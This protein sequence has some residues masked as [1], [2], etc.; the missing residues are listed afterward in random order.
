MDRAEGGRNQATRESVSV[1]IPTLHSTVIDR[2][3]QSLFDQSCFDRITEILVVGLD[4]PG[5]VMER[6][7]VRF[8]DTG[9]PVDPPVARNIGIRHASGDLLAFIDSDC[10]ATPMWLECLLACRVQGHAV[11]AGGVALETEGYRSLCYNLG[12]FPDTLVASPAGSRD[13]VSALNLLVARE[14]VDAVGVFN[15]RLPRSEDVE[16]SGRVRRA[17][18]EIHFSPQAELIHLPEPRGWRAVLPKF[19]RSGFYSSRVR[20]SFQD[21]FGTPWF[22][23]HRAILLALS[24]FLSA[25][26]VLRI[27][28]RNRGVLRYVH[29]AP[30]LFVCKM[31]WCL[32]AAA[33]EEA[34]KGQGR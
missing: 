18:F 24:P 2:T 9:V 14:I 1:I 26:A 6:A 10:V 4:G 7:P 16:W 34:K 22:F 8:L 5:L 21:V 33:R 29:T 13:S 25:G 17:G 3:L 32:G 27:F 12:S 11:V 31:A 19:Y 20:V 30:M 23:G 28:A 15:P